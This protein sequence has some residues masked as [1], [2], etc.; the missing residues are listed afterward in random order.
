MTDDSESPW[1]GQSCH[2]CGETITADDDGQMIGVVK[3]DGSGALAAVHRECI[4]LEVIG[5][6][7][8]V[9]KCTGW[10][11]DRA[12]ALEL[13]RRINEALEKGEPIP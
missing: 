6:L 10:E 8:G 11:Y 4:A 3:E 9:C 7:W 5:H 13:K 2:D 12:A 1:V